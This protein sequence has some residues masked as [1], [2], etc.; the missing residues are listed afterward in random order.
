[1]FSFWAIFFFFFGGPEKYDFN[2]LK[3]FLW[4]SCPKLSDFENK[5]VRQIFTI[6]YNI[7]SC[8]IY[9]HLLMGDCQF[10]TSQNC[11]KKNPGHNVR[12]CFIT[13]HKA[14]VYTVEHHHDQHCGLIRGAL[15]GASSILL[16]LFKM[17]S[18]LL[19]MIL[20]T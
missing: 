9:S 13:H 2:T 11:N 4:K 7:L 15:V 5:S 20:P 3:R 6:G 8:M 18:A 19:T 10:A 16:T 14:H 12:M 1:M 17:D